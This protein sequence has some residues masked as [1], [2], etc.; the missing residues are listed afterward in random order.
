MTGKQPLPVL[1]IG[2]IEVAGGILHFG[3]WSFDLPGI[4]P[5][6]LRGWSLFAGW[7]ARELHEM[8]HGPACRCPVLGFE[9]R[10]EI[11][12]LRY[13]QRPPYVIDI[14]ECTAMEGQS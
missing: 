1:T 12:T 10:S 11:M 8:S 13:D 7:S 9:P 5:H 14:A 3:G 4:A 2:S 6:L